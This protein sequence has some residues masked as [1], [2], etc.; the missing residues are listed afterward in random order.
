MTN[1]NYLFT[2]RIDTMLDSERSLKEQ[3]MLTKTALDQT[4]RC[5]KDGVCAHDKKKLN[6]LEQR[7]KQLVAQQIQKEQQMITAPSFW[8]RSLQCVGLGDSP[9]PTIDQRQTS[10][11]SLKKE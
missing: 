8:E 2:Q 6:D 1:T 4:A 10:L 7:Q 11:L 9:K 5:F 3:L